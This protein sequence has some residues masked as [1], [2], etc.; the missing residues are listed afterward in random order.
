MVT[1]EGTQIAMLFSGGVYKL[2]I[3][4][5]VTLLSVARPMRLLVSNVDNSGIFC[6]GHHPGARRK[7]V[8]V[9]SATAGR[10]ATG[11]LAALA[12]LVH[13]GSRGTSGLPAAASTGLPHPGAHCWA[14]WYP[15]VARTAAVVGLV[16]SSDRPFLDPKG[17]RRAAIHPI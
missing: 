5:A 2:I 3:V 9:V 7:R 10:A 6:L 1:F 17:Y 4:L 16:R 14:F 12:E 15:L 11:C 13:H 8:E